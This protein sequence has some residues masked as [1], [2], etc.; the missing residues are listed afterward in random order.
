M[1]GCIYIDAKKKAPETPQDTEEEMAQALGLTRHQL[2]FKAR[3]QLNELWERRAVQ[4]TAEDNF[5]RVRKLAA[6]MKKKQATFD[7]SST[8]STAWIKKPEVHTAGLNVNEP[9]GLR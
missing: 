6:Q 8:P 4:R 3:H 2:Q 9:E 7:G 1:C 5:E